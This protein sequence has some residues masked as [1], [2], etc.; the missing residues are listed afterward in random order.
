MATPSKDAIVEIA[1]PA[2]IRSI[3]AIHRRLLAAMQSANAI[4]VDLT[5]AADADITLIQLLETARRHASV[6]AKRLTLSVPAAGDLRDQL[7]RGGFLA[8]A[9]GRAFWLQRTEAG[10]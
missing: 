7:E 5:Q 10:Q 3:E 4:V 8:G 9:D 1:G 6:N 2:D